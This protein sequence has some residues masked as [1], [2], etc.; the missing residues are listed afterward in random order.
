MFD[1]KAS[2]M[3]LRA[4]GLT[5]HQSHDIVQLIQKWV[6]CSGEEWAV[7]RL[8]SMK[9]D[10]LRCYAGLSPAKAHSWIRYGNDGAPK[11]PFKAIFRLSKKQFWK[12][13]NA[14]MVYTGLVYSHPELRVTQRQWRKMVEAVRRQPVPPDALVEGLRLVHRSPFFVPLVIQESTGRPLMDYVPS[15]ARRA[16]K[17]SETVPEISGLIDSLVPLIQ[18]T[19]WSVRNWDI[20]SGVMQG[21]ESL[22]LPDMELNLDD[23]SK[24][25]SPPLDEDFLPMMGVIALIQEGGY[26]LRFAANPYRLYQQ[27][28]APL[29][30]ALF[31]ALKRVPNDFTFDQDSGAQQVQAWLSAGY[32]SASMDL[33]NATDNAPLELQ[34]ALLSRF[35]VSTRWLQFFKDCCRGTWWVKPRRGVRQT[36]EWSVGSPLGLYPTFAS[37]ALWHH[38]LVQAC[39]ADL[40]IPKDPTTGLWPY[41]IVGDDVWLGVWRV[42]ELY[43]DRMNSLGVPIS[44]TKTLWAKDTAEFIGRV[45]RPN[46]MVQGYKWKGRVSDENFVD[47]CRNIGP[48]ALVLLRARQKWVIG[49]IA[50]L[51]E[52]YGL[53]WNPLGIPLEER[54]TPLIEKE[55]SRDERVRSFDRRAAWVH[56]IL[57]SSVERSQQYRREIDVAPLASDQEV[58][59]LSDQFFP[60]WNLG[61]PLLGNVHELALER[62]VSS[63]STSHIKTALVFKRVSY[64]EKRDEVPTLVQLERKIRRVLSRSR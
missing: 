33:S 61:I 20:L 35:G 22:V 63:V 49:F 64:L 45:I 6:V 30:D 10:L 37:F 48:G 46:Q 17:G 15:P 56:R 43:R 18:R 12:A 19:S 60:G 31:G 4:L 8:K 42:A 27:A 9:V 58:L 32:E 23:E 41:A 38:S 47:L 25:G 3:R 39:F 11:G 53:G 21:I 44:E 14:V 54:L 16:P 2:V 7:D 1:T 26:K 13:W 59:A 52:P 40:D 36:L 55:W 50:D 28:L 62:G 29:G 57:Y 51:P 34:L 24:S 5:T